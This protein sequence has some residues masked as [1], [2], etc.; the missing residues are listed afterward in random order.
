MNVLRVRRV[1]FTV[2]TLAALAAVGNPRS[3]GAQTPGETAAGARLE[4]ARAD[5]GT[6]IAFLRDMPKC[7]DLHMH[8][9]GAI[10]PE[11]W[12]RWA[13]ADHLCFAIASSSLTNPP[14]DATDRVPAERL[15]TDST[16]RATAVGAWS[17]S[18]WK[19]ATESGADHFFAT[20]AKTAAVGNSHLGQMLAEITSE[21]AAEH[22]SYLELMSNPDE[23][24]IPSI[25]A[26]LQWTGDFAAM[27]DSVIAAGV[28]DAIKKASS[29]VDRA[30]RERREIQRCDTPAAERG[31]FVTVRYIY[32]GVRS[33]TPAPVFA[34][35]VGAFEWPSIDPRF[36]SVNLVAPEHGD[37]AV[38][39]F[40]LHMRMLDWLH[41]IYPNVPITL[42]AGELSVRVTSR[43]TM[44]SH[45]RES[46]EL[47]H[48]SRIG[49]GV[50]VLEEDDSETLLNEMAKRH[51]LVEVAL[52]SNDM[53]LGVHG[54]AHPLATY[55]AHGVPTA[56]ATDDEGVSSSDLTH[57]YF[58]AVMDQ[59]SSYRT[60]KTMAR[61][62]IAYSF[63][64]DTTKQRLQSELENAFDRFE[65]P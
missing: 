48:A 22:I 2:S 55:L 19:P 45:I 18:G 5:S 51:I 21:A 52:T 37:V 23:G 10:R 58:R 17:M 33:R 38:R 44:R 13:A 35:L 36:V 65:R 6:L 12:I 16:L 64:P 30:E 40:D 53:I 50:D 4:S 41:N 49:H 20:F 14:C 42:H 54:S 61:N 56:L 34:Q 47:G 8:L 28:R 46:V 63:A 62:S 9:G 27:R 29:V 7:G 60:L 31:C 25:G 24:S 32:Q 1:L 15:L 57:E 26:K 39:D 43:E 59:H 3:I 11:S